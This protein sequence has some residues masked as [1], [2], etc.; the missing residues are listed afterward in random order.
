M[1]IPHYCVIDDIFIIVWIIRDFFALSTPLRKVPMR[2]QGVGD[3]DRY[4]LLIFCA[5][6]KYLGYYEKALD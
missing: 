1:D 5:I 2:E 6:V 4:V 3:I